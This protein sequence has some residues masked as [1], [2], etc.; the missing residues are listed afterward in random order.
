[1]ELN[2]LQTATSKIAIYCVCHCTF[3]FGDF[4]SFLRFYRCAWCDALIS[5][6]Y[7]ASAQKMRA[8]RH[9][10]ATLS[11]RMILV[12]YKLCGCCLAAY[13]SSRSYL[14]AI[15][16]HRNTDIIRNQANKMKRRWRRGEEG[17]QDIKKNQHQHHTNAAEC[18][19]IKRRKNKKSEAYT[20]KLWSKRR[21]CKKRLFMRMRR[22]MKS[23]CAKRASNV[24]NSINKNVHACYEQTNER[25]NE[26]GRS[27][28]RTVGC[29]ES[30]ALFV[31]F[32]RLSSSIR[33]K[34]IFIR[35]WADALSFCKY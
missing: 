5:G 17:M 26:Y 19:G 10:E 31:Q 11:M 32:N 29:L 1:M 8:Q 27:N 22:R 13:S 21:K 20:H 30:L 4:F 14:I 18:D 12:I 28:K 6:K 33:T 23:V 7:R 16:F 25:T 15:A 24:H 3:M 2:P 34:R 9:S 35:L